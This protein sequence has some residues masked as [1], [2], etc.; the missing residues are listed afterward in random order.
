MGVL[1]PCDV[2]Q[3]F[4]TVIP[5]LP[6]VYIVVFERKSLC[7]AHTY[8]VEIMLHFREGVFRNKLFRILILFP[9]LFTRHLCV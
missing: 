6:P 9:Y 4:L 2:C 1:L 5:F 8:A 7:P 3:A